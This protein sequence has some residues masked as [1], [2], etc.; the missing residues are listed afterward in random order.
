MTLNKHISHRILIF[1]IILIIIAFGFY[2]KYQFYNDGTEFFQFIFSTIIWLIL[3]ASFLLF[4]SSELKKNSI[5]K[6]KRK[7]NLI[8]GIS[9]FIIIGIIIIQLIFGAAKAF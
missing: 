5:D 4:E 8:T 1:G 3:S 2:L 7:F 9:I 6:K